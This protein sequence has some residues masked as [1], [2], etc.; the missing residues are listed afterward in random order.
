[1]T[2]F[3]ILNDEQMSNKVGVVRTNQKDIGH[4]AG[5]HAG[6]PKTRFF[7]KRGF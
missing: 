4:V 2:I 3:P 1:M 7:F 6:K 5:F